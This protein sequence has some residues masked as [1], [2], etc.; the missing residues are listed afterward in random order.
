M[1][2]VKKGINCSIV[3]CEEKAS[4]SIS[5][6]DAKPLLGEGLKFREEGRR[7]YLCSTHYKLLKKAR[8]KIEKLERWR[9]GR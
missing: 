2:K 5:F 8:K 3:N 1:G 4:H 7:V 6:E 9:F